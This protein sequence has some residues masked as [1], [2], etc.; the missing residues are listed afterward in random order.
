MS[1]ASYGY[2]A[3]RFVANSLNLA[4]TVKWAYGR[5]ADAILPVCTDQTVFKPAENSK[6]GRPG[7]IRILVVG[8][9]RRGSGRESLDF[10][11]MKDIRKAVDLLAERN[12]P[13][14][15]VRMANSPAD[16]FK[17]FPCEYHYCPNDN[18]KTRLFGSADI[19]I[20]A[21]HYDSCP[22]PPQEAMASGTAVVCTATPG[23]IEYCRHRQN[24]LLVPVSSP[25]AIADAV[26]LLIKDKDLR[27]RLVKGGLETAAE[28]PREREWDE[29]E[30]LLYRFKDAAEGRE[31]VASKEL[32]RPESST[33]KTTHYVHGI[34][35][36]DIEG[37]ESVSDKLQENERMRKFASLHDEK[38]LELKEF[39]SVEKMYEEAQHLVK[40]G[41]VKTAI[42]VLESI[43]ERYEEFTPAHNDLGV[44][45]YQAGDMQSAV[46][47]YERAVEIEPANKVFRM[48]LAD[49]YCMKQGRIEEAMR[50]Y[51]DL[52]AVNPEDVEV[53]M[54][55]GVICSALQ[56]P[57]DAKHFYNRVLEHQPWNTDARRQLENL[58][59]N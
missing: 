8:S 34:H 3:V 17:G 54:S 35:A 48:N 44:L 13:F 39:R 18:V 2:P 9:D 12:V 55:M 52:L 10:K 31:A 59:P 42:A 24:S 19:L 7:R 32:S 29:L 21:S 47:H 40:D 49:F 30:Q 57:E 16:I 15:I 25:K 38:N 43:L 46:H 22:R 58:Y 26:Q 11:G 5:T 1:G 50:M 41:D 28:Y 53:L 56:R 23:A 51:V 33:N 6:N 14:L 20:Y 4:N 36:V 27:A 37:A 45:Y